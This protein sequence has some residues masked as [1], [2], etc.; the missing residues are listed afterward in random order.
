MNEGNWEE[1]ISLAAKFPR[2]G[3][4]RGE[5]LDAHMAYTN[6]RFA[7]QIGKDIDAMKEAGMS[8]LIVRFGK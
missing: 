8:A 3:T 6:P 7:K 2:L 5:I 1:A 4:H